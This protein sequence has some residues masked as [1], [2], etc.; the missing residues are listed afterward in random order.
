MSTVEK[1]IFM[2]MDAGYV[3]WICAAVCICILVSVIPV[4]CSP[5]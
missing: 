2:I 5:E 4:G 3:F 1:V